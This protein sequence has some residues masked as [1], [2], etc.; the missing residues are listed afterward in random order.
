MFWF[1]SRVSTSAITRAR[2]SP[3]RTVVEHLLHLAFGLLSIEPLATNLVRDEVPD[4]LSNGVGVVAKLLDLNA[5]P[6]FLPA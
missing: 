1:Y 4:E 2:I 3:G 6:M 5:L